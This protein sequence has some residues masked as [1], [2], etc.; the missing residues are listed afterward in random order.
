MPLNS[1]MNSGVSGLQAEGQALGVVGDNVANSNTVG[2]KESRALFED[3]L[4]SAVGERGTVGSGVHVTRAQQLFA[5]GALLNTGQPTDLAISG[6][7][8]FVVQ[9][10]VNGVKGDFYTRA[11]QTNLAKDGSLVNPGGL[12]LV[13][14]KVN[15]NGTFGP[16]LAPVKLTTAA[17]PPKP[18]SKLTLTANVDANSAT[19]VAPFDPLNPAATSNFS[20][21][22]SVY[23]SLGGAHAVSVYMVNNG[24]GSW[25]YH[26][27]ANGSELVGGTPGQSV[28]IATGQLAFT[29]GGALQSAT[30]TAGGTADFVGAQAGQ[31][32]T[33]NFGTPIASGGTGLDGTT[34]FASPSSVSSQSQDGYASGSLS[35]VAIDASGIVS[36]VYT[37]GQKVAVAQLAIAKFVSNDGLGRAG[38]NLWVATRDSGDGALGTAGSGGR[39]AIVAGA[40]EQ[41]N[42]DIAQQFVDLIG[43]QRSFQAC[44]KTIT[45]VDEMMQDLVNLK[46]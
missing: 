45:T 40:L 44:S 33:F 31:A 36:G 28:E 14:Y 15:A 11:G 24:S 46:R 20:T 9:G 29:P 4:G 10:A 12:A 25:D 26:A 3:V 18:T 27:L 41:S 8:F 22:M 38:N 7:G 19:P 39:G 16:T 32:L 17:L 34:Q 13:G 42:V 5:Q 43:H 37:N 2:F 35:G 23:D 1:A 21:S 6:D 30:V